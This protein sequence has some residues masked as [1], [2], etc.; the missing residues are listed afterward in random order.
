MFA[1]LPSFDIFHRFVSLAHCYN[2]LKQLIFI[3]HYTLANITFQ[4][5]PTRLSPRLACF[6]DIRG[7]G[8]FDDGICGY[9]G[10]RPNTPRSSTTIPYQSEPRDSEDKDLIE[11]EEKRGHLFPT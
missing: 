4:V 1:L 7:R 6:T 8:D 11:R 3:E 10:K 9:I 5:I 2:R